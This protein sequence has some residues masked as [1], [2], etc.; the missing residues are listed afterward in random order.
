MHVW[1]PSRHGYYITEGNNVLS[2]AELEELLLTLCGNF[3]IV[4]DRSSA[5][6]LFNAYP[7]RGA[8][9]SLS[10]RS[11]IELSHEHERCLAGT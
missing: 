11:A 2:G 9:I 5:F 4:V 7:A 8:M 1:Y 3:D 6:S 10:Q